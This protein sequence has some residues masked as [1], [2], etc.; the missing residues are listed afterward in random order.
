MLP[1]LA[2]RFRAA[3]EAR[4]R[5]LAEVHRA[6]DGQR[7]FRPEPGTWCMLDVTE[8]LVLADERSVRGVLRGPDE[9]TRVTLAARGRMAIVRLVLGVG[10]RVKVRITGVQP[11]GVQPLEAL[12]ARWAKAAQGLK[13]AFDPLDARSAAGPRFRHPLTG[14]VSA[15]EGLGFIVSHINHHARQ[16]RRIRSARGLPPA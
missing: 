14:W 13:D 2:R 5:F 12:E 9:G 6:S 15:G 7:R 3:D 10:I 8:H 16:L 11:E 4:S 1:A